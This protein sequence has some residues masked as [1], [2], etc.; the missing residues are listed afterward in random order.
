MSITYRLK[1]SEID[2]AFLDE[3]KA[4]YGDKEIEITVDEID[5]TDYLLKSDAN[6]ER[7]LNAIESVNQGDHLVEV[8]WEA[9]E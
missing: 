5:E 6:R 9:L 2:Q 1:A 7:L 8:S 3:L 4:K